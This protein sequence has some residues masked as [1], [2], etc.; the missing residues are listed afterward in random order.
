METAGGDEDA[1]ENEELPPSEEWGMDPL[2]WAHV[3]VA[4][5]E[6]VGE[7]A[8]LL[9][10]EGTNGAVHFYRGRPTR[11]CEIMGYVVTL[12]VRDTKT[13]FTG[14]CVDVPAK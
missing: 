3:K 1:D 4:V 9:P 6:V 7:G 8:V 10:A 2:F 13:I 14:A 12:N 5:C 11:K